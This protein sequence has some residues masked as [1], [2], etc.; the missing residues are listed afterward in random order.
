VSF[1][2]VS[3]V[4]YISHDV[5]RR[6]DEASLAGIL[7]MRNYRVAFEGN[8]AGEWSR[9]V[10]VQLTSVELECHRAVVLQFL[11]SGLWA[12]RG[13]A[14]DRDVPLRDDPAYPLAADFLNACVA[15]E[16][17]AALISTHLDVRLNSWIERHYLPVLSGDAWQLLGEAAAVYTSPQV[18]GTYVPGPENELLTA[19]NGGLLVFCESGA[20]RWL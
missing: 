14:D 15:S 9:F 4:F 6:S 1:H 13:D 7:G 19:E 2:P 11:R 10:D 20:R 8:A 5:A 16:S 3:L 18:I 17:E 12:L